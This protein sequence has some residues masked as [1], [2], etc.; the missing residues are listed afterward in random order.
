MITHTQVNTCPKCGRIDR[1]EVLETITI[2]DAHHWCFDCLAGLFEG[3]YPAEPADAGG[4]A[5][6][7][8][9]VMSE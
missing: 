8:I 5:D 6:V 9:F 2:H 7:S 3:G 4:F 1:W